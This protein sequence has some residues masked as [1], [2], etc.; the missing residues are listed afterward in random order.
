MHQADLELARLRV[1]EERAVVG[2]G[3]HPEAE[4]LA[5]AAQR[6]LAL[7]VDVAREPGR[8]EVAGLVLDPLDRALEQDRGQ[9][10]ADVARVDRHLVAEAAA[11]VGRDDP[12]HLLGDLGHH[13]DRGPDDVR[14]LAGHVDRE[15]AG[16]PVEVGDR[17]A[18]LDRRRVAARVVQLQL[19]DH[20]GPL[21]GPVG[22]R[23]VADLPVVD[24]VVGLVDLVVADH[25]RVRGQPLPRVHDDRQRL[26]VDVD[27]LARVLG[28]VRVVGDDAGHLLALEA[29]LVGREHRLG[30]IGERGHPGEVPGRHHLAGQHQA[31]AG[32]RPRPAGVD[33]LDARVRQRAAQDLH[34]QH[35]REHH[36]VG[37]VALA[38]DE[39]V[40]LDPLAAGAEPADLDLVE[41]P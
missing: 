7:E 37:V 1:G 38:P 41:R 27:Q 28:D 14:R 6:H 5:V 33:R 17:A 20:V 32:Q 9:D 21:E 13:R 34:V 11:D 25:R 10:R 12:D 18:A 40:V 16:G 23:L 26:V 2:V 8:D 36:V 29:H 30:V 24:D 4:D 15:L 22:A 39:A 35:A 19:G 31:D 3:V